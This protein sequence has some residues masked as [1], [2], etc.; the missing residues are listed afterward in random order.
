MTDD[1]ARKIE[2]VLWNDPATGAS[3]QLVAAY[4]YNAFASEIWSG[5]TEVASVTN[6]GLLDYRGLAY[7][8]VPGLAQ[9]FDAK[10]AEQAQRGL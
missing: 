2:R 4:A 6:P 5:F 7:V 3:R 9:A 10:F 1:A 8:Q